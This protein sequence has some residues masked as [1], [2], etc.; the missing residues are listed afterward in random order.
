M[1][2]KPKQLEKK[3]YEEIK[4]IEQDERVEQL[5]RR[6]KELEAKNPDSKVEETKEELKAVQIQI[7]EDET[8][9]TR[10]KSGIKEVQTRLRSNKQKEKGLRKE[11]DKFQPLDRVLWWSKV[12]VLGCIGA[13]LGG[14]AGFGT[15]LFYLYEWGLKYGWW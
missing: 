6:I 4:K 9:L 2:G 3:S 5:E 15:F 7:S 13:F 8:S 1:M 10:R 11:L 12:K 14:L